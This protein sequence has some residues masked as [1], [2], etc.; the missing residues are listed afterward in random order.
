MTDSIT[1]RD[2]VGT[3]VAGCTILTL[4]T[5]GISA[6]A[7]SSEKGVDSNG[8]SYD[9]IIVGS[10]GG[11]L[12]SALV[13]SEA[14]LKSVIFEK[15]GFVGGDTALSDGTIHAAGTNLQQEQGIDSGDDDAYIAE[16]T[17]PNSKFTSIDKPLTHAL[18]AGAR[19]M[20]NELS[21]QGLTFVPIE[22]WDIWA[23]NV[24]GKGA[25]LVQFLHKKV[26][27]AGV[28]IKFDTPVAALLVENDVV[29]GV[30]T[31]SGEEFRS[32]AVILA[33]GGFCSGADLVERYDPE[34]SGVLVVGSPGAEGDGLVM[35]QEVGAHTVALED[36][37]HTYIV[38]QATHADLSY[39]MG[40]SSG[41]FV[42]ISGDRFIAEDA[43]YDIT[44]KACIAQ[45]EHRGF[46][47][48]DDYAVETF[49]IFDDYFASGVVDEYESIDEMAAAL[50]TPALVQTIADYN[51]MMDSGVDTVFGREYELAKL[52]GPKFYSMD[53]EGCV[54][55]S[56]GGLDIDTKSRV[57]DASGTPIPGLY[58]CGEVIASPEFREGLIYTSGISAGYVFG[59]IA[60][61]SIQED[62]S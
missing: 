15:F 4:G 43:H 61:N 6:C 57:L 30:K 11:G 37:L 8:A 26:E 47:I 1:R 48:F 34:F 29:V 62:L 14:G 22:D 18:Y 32:N 2:F 20:V 58:A 50:N 40:S 56:Y 54:Y 45:P 27:A 52:V 44:G 13:S 16:R 41:I 42:N 9:I 33:T 23:H 17:D 31:D 28:E 10:G 36:G 51:N 53:G 55:F 25:G 21:E 12:K 35:G 7:L 49:G 19:Q 59:A 5:L 3:A 60:V 39:P 38:T 46:F 24:D